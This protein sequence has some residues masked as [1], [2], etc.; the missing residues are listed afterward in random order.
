MWHL[1]R[2]SLQ[3]DESLHAAVLRGGQEEF[4]IEGAVEKY[5]GSKIDTI[6]GPNQDPF[7][8]LTI[9]HAVRMM[10]QG[11]RPD[12]D[13]EDR[14]VM[15]WQTPESALEI[16]KSQAAQTNRPELDEAVVVE[17]FIKACNL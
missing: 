14:T 9:Y 15:E 3:G 12:I 1:V 10:A 6:T 17:R 4:G 2:E 16:Y 13:A 5:L 11:E 7:E 8:K